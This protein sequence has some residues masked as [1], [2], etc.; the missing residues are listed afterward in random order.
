[1]I[2]PET[3]CSG[4]VAALPAALQA[5]ADDIRAEH[6]ADA[7]EAVQPVHV[8]RGIMHRDIMIEC[9]VNGTCTEAV[10]NRKDAQRGEFPRNGKAEEC[11]SGQQDTEKGDS[12]RFERPEQSAGKQAGNDRPAGDD[13]GEDART[14]HRNMQPGIH[15]GPRGT[16]QGIRQ[17]ETDI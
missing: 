6:T 9:R 12:P 8:P 3:D 1:M 11:S 5:D 15:R 13:R 2:L 14:G 7:P 17:P 16:Q 4:A 10:R